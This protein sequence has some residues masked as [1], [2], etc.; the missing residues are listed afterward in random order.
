MKF[1]FVMDPIE[2]IDV[3]KDTT[4]VFLEEAQSRGHQNYHCGIR[5]LT[6]A[7]GKVHA[8]CSPLQV[9][10][11]QGSH[12]AFGTSAF[13]QAETFDAVF[14][15]KDPPFDI[16]FFF[17]THLLSL[18]DATKTFVFNN[19]RGLRE[20]TEKLFIMHFP[21]LIPETL[22]SSDAT[23]ILAFADKVGGDIVVKPLDGCGGMGIFRITQGDLNTNSILET[24]TAEGKR[25]I[26]A[27]RFLPESRQGDQRLIYLDGK[28]LGSMVRVPRADDL[29]GNIHVGGTC[30]AGQVGPRELEICARLAPALDALGIYF[31]GL[32]VIGDRLTEVNVTSPTGVQEINTLSHAKLESAVIDFVETKCQA[33]GAAGPA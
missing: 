14:M 25:Q 19:P 5:D 33:L 3:T 16:D 31:A 7:D 28:A 4:F 23:Q 11:V 15:R 6:V 30:I 24:V 9:K 20:A 17:S 13:V 18:I 29:R 12:W 26:M 1:L 27:Q 8:T 32:D 10:P 22:V 2:R 21:D